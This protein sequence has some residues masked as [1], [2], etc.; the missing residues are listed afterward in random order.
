MKKFFIF[1][2][3]IIIEA[4]LSEAGNSNDSL[5]NIFSPVI[6]Q[7]FEELNVPGVIAGIWIGDGSRFIISLG[8]SDIESKT[9]M[10]ADDRVRIAS[11]TKTFTGTVILQLRD[12]GKLNLSDPV[13]KYLPDYPDGANITIEQLGTM[14]SGIFEYSDDKMFEEESNKNFDKPFTPEQLIEVAEKHPPYFPPG[15]GVYYSNTNFIILGVIIEKITGNDIATEIKKRI[16]EPLEMNST[17]FARTKDFPEPHAH[18][19]MYTDSSSDKPVDVSIF[20]PDWAWAS[21]A[22]IS[23]MNDLYKYAKPLIT[24]QLLSQ[25]SQE[26][27]MT[28]GPD[29]YLKFGTWKDRAIKYG[30]ALEDFGDAYG[31][32]GEIPGF[33]SFMAY[34]PEKDMTVIVLANMMH[35]KESF[36]PADYI[37]RAILKKVKSPE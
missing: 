3:L 23:T 20:D 17:L 33:N 7:A 15:K 36:S 37:A 9:P 26:S 6:R 25:S 11:I 14:T 10:T 4:S 5:E 35:N 22:M 27:R 29:L 19:Y 12:E 31:H 1:F 30:F 18:G 13:S 16:L 2:F 34:I 8:F 21:G 32:C 28:W 24:G